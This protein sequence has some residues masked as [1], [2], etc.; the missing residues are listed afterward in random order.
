[1]F[2]TAFL[3]KCYFF[4]QPLFPFFYFGN[5]CYVRI[6]FLQFATTFCIID[7]PDF[8]SLM[9]APNVLNVILER[10]YF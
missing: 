10:I 9:K 5:S 2:G 8:S 6:F 7:D 4:N 3:E 1:M